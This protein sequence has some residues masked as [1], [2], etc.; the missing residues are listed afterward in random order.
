[1]S[2]HVLTYPYT[3]G[4]SSSITCHFVRSLG[5]PRLWGERAQP[6]LGLGEADAPNRLS[7]GSGEADMPDP[8]PMGLGEVA[9]SFSSASCWAVC[10][11]YPG[12]PFCGRLTAQ[13]AQAAYFE[14]A[15]P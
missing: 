7:L 2:L 1:M 6:A 14:G 12:G 10:A 15:N 3:R 9:V 4:S 11:P 5:T 8:F 13:L